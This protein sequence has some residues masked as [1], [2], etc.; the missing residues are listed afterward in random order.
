MPTT[1]RSLI[2]RHPALSYFALT[3]AISIGGV[4][5]VTRPSGIFGTREEFDR[6]MLL[7][8]LALVAGPSVSGLLMTWLVGGAQGLRE[9]RARLLRW[10]VAGRWYAIALLTA[11]VCFLAVLLALSVSSEDFLPRIFVVDDPASVLISGMAV[12]LIAGLF[13]ELGWTGFAVPMLRKRY[14]VAATGLIL[15][16]VWGL[17]HFHVKIW[18][19]DAFGMVPYLPADLAS[20]VIGLTGFRLLMVWVHE[21]THSLLLA[22]LMH[23]SLTAS[24]VILGIEAPGWPLAVVTAVQALGWWVVLA[25]LVAAGRLRRWRPPSFRHAH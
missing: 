7:W 17:W 1:L 12:G 4:L 9:Y 3:F 2:R 25:G 14:G 11:P 22:I 13:E 23:A 20:A 15:G 18:S 5:L 16:V 19:A 24:S 10:R 21:R 6:L 8:S